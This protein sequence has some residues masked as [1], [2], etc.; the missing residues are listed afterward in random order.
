MY[1]FVLEVGG[2]GGGGW[3]PL[4]GVPQTSEGKNVARMRVNAPLLKNCP[5][6]FPPYQNSVS[7]LLSNS[8]SVHMYKFK[9]HPG[10]H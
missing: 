5:H 2:G 1:V 8:Q 6:L 9:N 10:N 4:L 7:A 3:V